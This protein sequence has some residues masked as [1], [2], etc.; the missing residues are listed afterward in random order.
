MKRS[1]SQVPIDFY[2]N[3]KNNTKNDVDNNDFKKKQIK[4]IKT[5]DTPYITNVTEKKKENNLLRAA[6]MNSVKIDRKRKAETL[7]EN[8]QDS[9][10]IHSPLPVSETKLDNKKQ[11]NRNYI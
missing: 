8:K 7:E 9:K 6:I 4:E 2:F 3:K 5:T 10:D 1:L 11:K